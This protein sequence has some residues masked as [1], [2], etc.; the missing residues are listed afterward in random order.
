M[1]TLS[2]FILLI[3]LFLGCQPKAEY[4]LVVDPLS[5]LYESELKPF[6]YGV[7]SGDPTSSAVVL[8]TKLVP[9][10]S[11]P[12]AKVEWKIST[13]EDF[14][15]VLQTGEITV[16]PSSG[17]TAKVD[18]QDLSPG[19]TYYYQFEYEG[20]KSLIG[21]TKTATSNANQALNF[22]VV[23]CSNYE[24]GPFNAYGAIAERNDIDAVIHLGDYIYEYGAKGYGDTTTGR[25]H[26]PEHEILS[27]E[28]YRMRYGQ[29]RLDKD[30]REVHQMHPFFTIWDD[31]EIANNAYKDGA[32]NH[33]DNEGNYMT[34]KEIARKVY[35][36]WL[37]IREQE[38]LYRAVSYGDL[39]ELIL[40]DERLVGRTA[41]AANLKDSVLFE[42]SHTMLGKEQLNWF[43][44][45]LKSSDAQW[46]IIGNQVIFSYL[47]WGYPTFDFNM[48][49]WDGYPLEREAILKTIDAEKIED[50]VFITGDTH[51]SW[52]LEVTADPSG[53]Y[54]KKGA[55]AVEFGTTS[56][57]SGNSNER[58]VADEVIIAHEKKISN[59][60]INPHLKYTNLRDHGY[61][62]LRLTKEAATA[63]WYYTPSRVVSSRNMQLAQK[64]VT[65]SGS[66]RIE[67]VDKEE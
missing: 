15:N 20:Q 32:Q 63:E 33:Q 55:Y 19:Q 35:Y 9:E 2:T 29:Y 27:L 47:N 31:H 44:D 14:M 18:V 45:E 37:P 22:A 41:P 65:P 62:M 61:L 46:K 28:D 34:R 1:K 8:W 24:F 57:N 21:K 49:S 42:E 7:A 23:S 52:A 36:E 54:K 51:S 5:H 10:D 26:L 4:A 40:L 48:D 66:N 60:S 67:L 30:L 12:N 3:F 39:A 38:Q 13:D 59:S 56:I 6:Y 58:G 50:I 43:L 25:F 16:E 53:E 11:V 64:T 17:Y